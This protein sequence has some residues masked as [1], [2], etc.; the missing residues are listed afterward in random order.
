MCVP[1]TLDLIETPRVT[2]VWVPGGPPEGLTGCPFD[3]EPRGPDKFSPEVNDTFGEAS[4]MDGPIPVNPNV[5][6]VAVGEDGLDDNAVVGSV[7][8]WGHRS[9]NDAGG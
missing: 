2:S 8:V 9:V 4:R 5:L 6:L 7:D 3:D 1:S